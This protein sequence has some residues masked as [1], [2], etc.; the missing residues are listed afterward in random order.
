MTRTNDDDELFELF[1]A[2]DDVSASDELKRATIAKIAAASGS[3]NET[4]ADANPAIAVVGAD[5]E[6]L[7]AI[8]A[9]GADTDANPAITASTT[10]VKAH[11]AIT[12]VKTSGKAKRKSRWRTI[13]VAALAACLVLALSGSIAYAT[14][15]SYVEVTQGDDTSISLGVNCFGI[16]I[17]ATSHDK[18][19]EAVLKSIDLRNMPSDE[20]TDR[21]AEALESMRPE[22]PVSIDGK[23]RESEHDRMPAPTDS[24]ANPAEK[25]ND[26]PGRDKENAGDPSTASG[27]DS[28]SDSGANDKPDGKSDVKSDDTSEARPKANGQTSSQDA[29]KSSNAEKP[30]REGADNPNN[31]DKAEKGDASPSPGAEPAKAPEGDSGQSQAPPQGEQPRR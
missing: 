15:V 13:R 6:T 7:P 24:Q 17:T 21:A 11:P 5:T 28:K 12:A 3:A 14:P 30:A 26:K 1:S 9:V 22:K 10:A 2:L 25:N 4:D 8:T 18:T 31:T 19:G 23:M 16:A 27:S 20:A 29:P